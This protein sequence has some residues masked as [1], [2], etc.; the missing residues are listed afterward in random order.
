MSEWCSRGPGCQHGPAAYN[1][2]CRDPM[3]VEAVRLRQARY[4]AQ[5]RRTRDR[6]VAEH[7]LTPEAILELALDAVGPRA[8][9][10]GPA[11]HPSSATRQEDQ[12]EHIHAL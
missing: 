1:K 4:R 6:Y 3:A 12:R 8:L 10:P 7:Y 11:S 2:G 5:R 9:D